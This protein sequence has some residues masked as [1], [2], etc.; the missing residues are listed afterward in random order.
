MIAFAP[1]R[2]T[3]YM[4]SATQQAFV[5]DDHPWVLFLGGVG[6]GKS[7]AGAVRALKR[8]FGR[9]KPSLGLVVSPSY[10]MLRDA[11]WRT[12]LDVWAPLL[13][14]VV[15]HQ[16]RMI[17][18]TGDEVIFRSADDP[19]RL[20][21]P[22]AAWAWID[23]AALCEPSTWPIVIGR[24]RQHGTLGEAWATTTPKGHN[25]VY[26]TWVTN[27]TEQTSVHRAATWAN[28][29]IDRSFVSALASQYEGDFARQELEAEW[30]ADAEGVLI[31]WLDLEEARLRDLDGSGS[32]IAGVDVAGPGEDETAVYLRQGEAIVDLFTTRLPDARGPVLEFLAPFRHTGL[33][34]VNVDSAGLGYYLA[35]HLADAGYTVR[36]VNVGASPTTAAGRE[37]YSNLK[38]EL[39]WALRERFAAG[40][41]GNLTDRTTLGQLAGLKYE[42]DPR[43]KL[44]IEGKERARA[45]GVRSPDRAEALMLAFSP[46]HPDTLRARLYGLRSGSP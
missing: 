9:T 7:Y 10:P 3:E 23:E 1:T 16:W 8:R 44:K 2:S 15:A 21:G 26:E 42:H 35:R 43:G 46:E 33:T 29:F 17:M 4:L 38:A 20:R 19:E 40:E 32:L 28:P 36:D 13:E 25:W 14:R 24:L 31:P 11:T 27:A 37:R 12:A 45:R 18:T 41:I 22:N 34:A 5:D 6:A 30:V 39:Y